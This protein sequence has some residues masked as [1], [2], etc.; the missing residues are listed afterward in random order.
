MKG[1][2][3]RTAGKKPYNHISEEVGSLEA[4]AGIRAP[5]G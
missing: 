4:C 3:H 1:A 5:E 2:V